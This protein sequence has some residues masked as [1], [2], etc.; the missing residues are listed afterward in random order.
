[1]NCTRHK[2]EKGI[3]TFTLLLG[4]TPTILTASYNGVS[5]LK[6]AMDVATSPTHPYMG[7]ARLFLSVSDLCLGLSH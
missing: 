7:T 2:K 4:L 3:G 1:M 5:L 6:L